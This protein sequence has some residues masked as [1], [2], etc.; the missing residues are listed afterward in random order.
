MPGPNDTYRA[1]YLHWGDHPVRLIPRMRST[2]REQF[3]GDTAAWTADLLHRQAD[4]DPLWHGDLAEPVGDTEWLYLIHQHH[5]AVEVHTPTTD[6]RWQLYSRHLLA[7]H[8]DDLF[9]F[10]GDAVRCSGCGTVDEVEF[11]TRATT[12]ADAKP[13]AVMRCENC[14][15]TETTTSNFATHR[16]ST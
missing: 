1:F 16:A 11:A 7:T 13:D 2:W 6:D 9:V 10:T 14:G 12:E 5:A 15:R 8:P 3:V 4:G